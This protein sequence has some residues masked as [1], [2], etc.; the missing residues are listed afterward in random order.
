VPNYCFGVVEPWQ[1]ELNVLNPELAE[2]LESGGID[3]TRFKFRRRWRGVGRF[4]TNNVWRPVVIRL[5]HNPIQFAQ[6]RRLLER[7]R[8][9]VEVTGL[10][11]L[12]SLINLIFECTRL[13]RDDAVFVLAG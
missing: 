1:H 13:N 5:C 10:N 11:R 9:R 12:N 6:I 3:E 7:I 2:I 8:A 4:G